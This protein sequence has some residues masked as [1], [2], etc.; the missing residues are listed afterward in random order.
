MVVVRAVTQEARKTNL[1]ILLLP[2]TNQK[3]RCHIGFRIQSMHWARRMIL[4]FMFAG[5]RR[6]TPTL[7]RIMKVHLNFRCWVL[8]SHSSY[9]IVFS[10]LNMFWNLSLSKFSFIFKTMHA[11]FPL[12]AS[13]NFCYLWAGFPIWG[14]LYF[15]FKHWK[16]PSGIDFPNPE[17]ELCNVLTCII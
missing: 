3:L 7:A 9:L 11:G 12:W 2:P 14:S 13:P 10:S 15:V 4:F 17:E 1:V 6:K 16:F 8:F 5:S